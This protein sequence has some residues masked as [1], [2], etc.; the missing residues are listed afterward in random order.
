VHTSAPVLPD[1]PL[2]A[3][4]LDAERPGADRH[5]PLTPAGA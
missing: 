4:L 3:E 1:E 2:D 5:G